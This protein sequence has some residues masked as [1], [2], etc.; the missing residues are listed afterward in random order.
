M[1]RNFEL[2]Q[3]IGNDVDI[4][5]APNAPGEECGSV[6]E[7]H[8]EDREKNLRNTARPEIVQNGD[9]TAQEASAGTLEKAS[10]ELP[11][12]L[13]HHPTDADS[14]GNGNAY[15]HPRL[16]DGPNES[17][18]ASANLD[19]AQDILGHA[20]VAPND[21]LRQVPLR[22]STAQSQVRAM[23]PGTHRGTRKRSK[24]PVSRG[25]PAL[26]RWVEFITAAAKGWGSKMPLPDALPR[27]ERALIVREEEIKLVHNVFPQN[28]QRV[29]RVAL[30]SGVEVGAE[31][32]SICART[33][34]LL[35]ARADGRVCAVDANFKS[36]SL[37]K[38]LL[39]ESSKGLADATLES[40]PISNFAHNVA[41]SNLWFLPSGDAAAS[42]GFSGC[43]E[44]LKA[45]IAELR[46]AFQY[47]L[48]H[49]APFRLDA[50]SLLLSSW[51]DGV[52][53]VLEA[54]CARR[55]S[56]RRVKENL[57]A[58]NVAVLGVVL[59]N[60]SYP[61]PEALYQRL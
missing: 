50:N 18:A 33:A 2:L 36:P 26:S 51:T 44:R 1:S 5:R 7:H 39:T 6:S 10:A 40:G 35:A 43:S 29:P 55:D 41:G 31:C 52:V 46:E 25:Y 24:L 14:C 28:Q 8:T 45:R 48:I 60:R 15:R 13:E 27:T 17:F 3:Q 53:L 37:H 49:A 22:E 30:F 16:A 59:S 38:Y 58:A 47:V 20:P 32:A 34:Q 9:K 19:A 12:N 61:V 4:F 21:H 54:H 23:D 11:E 56:A 57:A 42:L